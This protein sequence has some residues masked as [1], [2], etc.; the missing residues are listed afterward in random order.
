[1]LKPERKQIGHDFSTAPELVDRYVGDVAYDDALKMVRQVNGVSTYLSW[2]VTGQSRH[3]ESMMFAVGIAGMDAVTDVMNKP[4]SDGRTE[5]ALRGDPPL[6]ELEALALASAI[7]RSPDFDYHV[8][9]LA[10]W[11]DKSLQQFED[12]DRDTIMSITRWK[13]AYSALAHVHAMTDDV[14]RDEEQY[15]GRFGFTMQLLDDYLDQPHDEAAG[16]STLFTEGYWDGA[17]LQD[18]IE[19][20]V[21]LGRQT[22][23]RPEAWDRFEK[24]LYAHKRMGDIENRFPGAASRLLP[25]Y[26]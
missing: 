26:F 1:M 12:P 7:S 6:K 13:G 16:Q 2:V 18:T 24:V 20:V 15:I 4:V 9:R 10:E 17:D 11:Q 8:M 23:D 5:A 21:E 22:Y 19:T 25:W 3:F 14:T